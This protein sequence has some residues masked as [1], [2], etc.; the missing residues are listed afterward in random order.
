MKAGIYYGIGKVGVEEIVKPTIGDNDVLVKNVRAGICGTDLSAYRYGG[1]PVA[2]YPNGEFGH[3]MVGIVVEVGKSVEDVLVGDRVFVNPVTCKKLG[4]IKC[5]TAGAFSEYVCVEE[6]KWDYNLFRIADDV[7]FDEAVVIEPFT[8]G[9]HGKNVVQTSNEDHV[10][11]YGAGTIG[12]SAL[13][14]VIAQGNKNVAIIDNNDLR[15]D[16]AKKLGAIPVNFEKDNVQEKLKEAFGVTYNVV[17]QKVANVNV[18]IDCA[19]APN[20]LVDSITNATEG[21]R[22]SLLATAQNAATIYP[23]MIMSN[24]VLIKG[25]CGYTIEDIKEVM[26]Y[27]NNKKTE[28]P[29]IVTHHFKLDEIQEAFAFANDPKNNTI[30]VV[31]DFE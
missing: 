7:S 13:A 14:G 6:A 27:I 24:E 10:L 26:N 30:K 5:D 21:I 31:I 3:E 19:G 20:V 25:S 15:L 4:K 12:L 22:I 16:F 28:L 1:E 9:T 17:G 11:I 2:I 23:A 29:K 18:V 8:V